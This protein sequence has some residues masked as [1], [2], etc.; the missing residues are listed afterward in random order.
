MQRDVEDVAALAGEPGRQPAELVVVLEQ[1]DL[2]AAFGQT[3]GSGQAG[4]TA[5]NDHDVVIILN[6]CEP[7]GGHE[8]AH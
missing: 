3:V 8:T 2:A 7:V 5:A 4:E 6:A 1:Q